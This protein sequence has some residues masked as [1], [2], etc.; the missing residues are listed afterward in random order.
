MFSHIGALF[1]NARVKDD[2]NREILL[3]YLGKQTDLFFRPIGAK[4]EALEGDKV[5]FNFPSIIGL[6][7]QL[8]W[9]NLDIWV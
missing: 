4:F 5:V 6:L 3:L 2:Y 7:L 9:E 1:P 8:I